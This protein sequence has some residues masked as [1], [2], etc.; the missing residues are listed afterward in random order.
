[1]HAAFEVYPGPSTSDAA[2]G[3]QDAV[4]SFFSKSPAFDAAR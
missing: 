3:F 2:F 1:L 4:I